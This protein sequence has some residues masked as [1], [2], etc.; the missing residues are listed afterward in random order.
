MA[1][2]DMTFCTFWEEC[3]DGNNCNRAL[4]PKV[5]KEAEL[6]WGDDNVLISTFLHKPNCFIQNDRGKIQK[7]VTPI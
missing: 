5:R 6:W 1:Y 3:K 2:K 4:T 7:E